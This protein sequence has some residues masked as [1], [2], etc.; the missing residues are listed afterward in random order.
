M[1]DDFAAHTVVKIM[2][3]GDYGVGKTSVILS[4]DKNTKEEPPK[5]PEPTICIDFLKR[6]AIVDGQSY[7]M[8]IWDTAG[9]ER[10]RSM[11]S[12]WLRRGDVLLLV[13]AVDSIESFDSLSAWVN[14]IKSYKR[15]ASV[16]VVLVGNKSDLKSTRMVSVQK[17]EDFAEQCGYFYCETSAIT[18]AGIEE[19]FETAVREAAAVAFDPYPMSSPNPIRRTY[20]WRGRIKVCET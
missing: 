8:Q 4:Y 6:N 12:S 20:C 3:V 15:D 1:A 18:G 17:A 9:T 13:F 11:V 10:Y 19:L 2:I 14:T 5:P 16:P 7:N